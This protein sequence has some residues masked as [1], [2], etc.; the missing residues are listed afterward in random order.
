MDVVNFRI[1]KS[2]Y[3]TIAPNYILL[4]S[5]RLFHELFAPP[6]P[7]TV[8]G[9]GIDIPSPHVFPQNL[10]HLEYSGEREIISNFQATN[11]LALSAQGSAIV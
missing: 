11:Q 7:G 2:P 6:P 4:L 9:G 3:E 1:V 10:S 5:D 8:W